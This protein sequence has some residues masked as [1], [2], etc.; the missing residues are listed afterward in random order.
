MRKWAAEGH[1]GFCGGFGGL[2]KYFWWHI[3]SVREGM[4][5]NSRFQIS[6]RSEPANM[7]PLF[8]AGKSS[9]WMALKE[10]LRTKALKSC[11]LDMRASEGRP[12]AEGGA[13]KGKRL[14]KRAQFP[15]VPMV[16][17]G[18]AAFSMSV[19]A[20]NSQLG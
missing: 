15:V 5:N 9:W 10:N 11:R 16:V 20:F 6:S 12:Q 13:A 4:K 7:V 17:V 14:V 1:I 3:S 8:K 2:E 19:S 18:T